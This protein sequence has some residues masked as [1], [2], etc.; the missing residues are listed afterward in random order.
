MSDYDTIIEM[1]DRAELDYR[2]EDISIED[3]AVKQI[4]LEYGYIGFITEIAFG[5]N[6][7]LV[8]IGAFE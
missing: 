1:L 5:L 7:E 2:V 8:S 6:G 4:Y 3:G